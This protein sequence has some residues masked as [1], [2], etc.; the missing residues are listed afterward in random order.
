MELFKKFE[1][2]LS[3]LNQAIKIYKKVL[4][5]TDLESFDDIT[6][7]LIKNGKI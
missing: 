3:N 1:I 7:D 6:K 2:E 5:V 4:N